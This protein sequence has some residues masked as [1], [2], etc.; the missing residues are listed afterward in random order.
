MF[1]EGTNGEATIYWSLMGTGNNA[2][3]VTDEDTGATSGIIQMEN[4]KDC[5]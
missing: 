1:R 3:Y 2:E 5:C 4:G